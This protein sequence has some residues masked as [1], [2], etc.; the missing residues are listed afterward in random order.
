MVLA[1]QGVR[2]LASPQREPE[3]NKLFRLAGKHQ[4][5]DLY[6]HVG[7]PP[8]LKIKGTTRETILRRLSQEVLEGLLLPILS[9]EQQQCLDQENEIGFTYGVE[10]DN[11]FRL[12]LSKK[13]GQITMSAHRIE[14]T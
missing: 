2:M 1:Y 8:L 10:K 4:A 9:A 14:A 6:L 11:L 3:I 13:R 12:E 7:L 5:S